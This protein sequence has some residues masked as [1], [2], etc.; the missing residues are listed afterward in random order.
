L[1]RHGEEPE[2]TKLIKSAPTGQGYAIGIIQEG[3][4]FNVIRISPQHKYITISKFSEF[5][6]ARIAANAEWAADKAASV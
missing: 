3:S 6:Q 1:Y 5:A 2:M 4:S